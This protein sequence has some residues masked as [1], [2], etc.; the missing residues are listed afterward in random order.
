[1][2]TKQLALSYRRNV[3]K[4]FMFSI[5]ILKWED[6]LLLLI[7]LKVYK[8]ASMDTGY[9]TEIFHLKQDESSLRRMNKSKEAKRQEKRLKA[10]RKIRKI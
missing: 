8:N 4:I 1:M 9:F 2:P 7:S 6:R 10:R 5:I 3:Q